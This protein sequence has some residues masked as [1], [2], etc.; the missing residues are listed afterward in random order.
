VTECLIEQVLLTVFGFIPLP[1]LRSSAG[2]RN[3]DTLVEL[4][5]NMFARP[6]LQGIL[7]AIRKVNTI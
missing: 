7:S 6:T 3:A 4:S 1:C 5:G 2:G